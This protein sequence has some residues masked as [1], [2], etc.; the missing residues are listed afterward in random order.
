MYAN[1]VR[2][3]NDTVEFDNAKNNIDLNSQNE[4]GYGEFDIPSLINGNSQGKQF[5]LDDTSDN[6]DIDKLEDELPDEL[7][8]YLR[9]HNPKSEEEDNRRVQLFI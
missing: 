7:K 2:Y 9:K 3:V 5:L 6:D 1:I 4:E 8:E